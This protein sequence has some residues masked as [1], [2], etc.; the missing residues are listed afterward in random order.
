MLSN[1][2]SLAAVMSERPLRERLGGLLMAGFDGLDVAGLPADFPGVLAG[3]ILFKR[4]LRDRAQVR[5]LTGML[6]D[7]WARSQAG[8]PTA[9]GPLIAVDQEGGTV[10]RL[11]G[12]WA[13][14][15]ILTRW[16]FRVK[17]RTSQHACK[18][19]LSL[20]RS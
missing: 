9:L 11:S 13:V 5:A 4:N 8:G 17:P 2:S 6:H 14:R 3:V 16:R 7:A 20:A 1:A 18:L 10:S 15:P 12:S 19:S